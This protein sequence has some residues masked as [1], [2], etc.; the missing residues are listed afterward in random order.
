MYWQGFFFLDI[1]VISLH[2]WSIQS[3]LI[4]FI[5]QSAGLP[6]WN[7]SIE[8]C[9][10]PSLSLQRRK[11][12]NYLSQYTSANRTFATPCN[13]E[14]FGGKTVIGYSIYYIHTSHRKP[15]PPGYYTNISLDEVAT[16]YCSILIIL[17][18]SVSCW[19]AFHCFQ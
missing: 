3:R 15:V 8:F 17:F 4:W 6:N 7:Q 1:W 18:S 5:S 19:F 12:Q 11:I 10:L 16:V 2:M 9:V 14:M 13:N